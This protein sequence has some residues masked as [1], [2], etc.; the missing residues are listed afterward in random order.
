MKLFNKT[1]LILFL[2]IVSTSIGQ[3]VKCNFCGE[4]IVGEYI[5]VDG[6][7]YHQNHFKCANCNKPINGDYASKDGKYYDKECNSNL[8]SL[9]CS[10]CNEPINGEYLIDDHGLKYHKYHEAELKRCDNCNR[11]ISNKTTLGGIVYNDGRNICNICNNKKLNFYKGYKQSFNQV[12]SRL[13]NY[14]LRFDESTIK[15]KIVDLNKLQ[16]IS[17][18]RYSK[19]I[20]GFTYTN[21]KTIGTNKTFEHTVYV[22][23][24]IPPKYAESTIAHELMHVWISENIEHK[25]DQHLEEGSCNYISYTYLKSD[26][27]DDAKEIVRQLHSNP[28]KIYGDGYRKV[29]DRFIGR[30]FNLFLDYLRKNKKI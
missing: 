26:Y 13:N 23:N 27:S 22:L 3:E 16:K 14:G 12:V 4:N 8:F 25:L 19:N 17:G 21:I 2:F 15:L 24:G 9:K 10:I 28:D 20:R 18:I 6:N 11:L 5:V 7:A 30:D 29:Y 1:Y